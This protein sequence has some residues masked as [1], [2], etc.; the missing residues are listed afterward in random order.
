MGGD[1]ARPRVR[2]RKKGG[3]EA[4]AGEDIEFAVEWLSDMFLLGMAARRFGA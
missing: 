3:K 4:G 2:R 1:G